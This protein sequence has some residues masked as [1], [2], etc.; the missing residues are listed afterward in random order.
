MQFLKNK[1][2]LVTL[3]FIYIPGL[4]VA[5]ATLD[6]SDSGVEK[7]LNSLAKANSQKEAIV[8]KEKIW[9]FWLIDHENNSAVEQFDV[10]LDYFERNKLEKANQLF[11]EIISSYP[12]YME[13]WNKRATI[14]FLKGDYQGSLAD[15]EEVLLRQK[16]HFGAISGAG[17]IY[18]ALGDDQRALRSYN[19]VLEIDP[20]NKE[21][22][23]FVLNLRDKLYG[24]IL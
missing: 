1:I 17:L 11:S 5:D 15:I 7:L 12:D 10:A 14:R 16:R 23:Y 6:S 4:V 21:A 9:Q 18:L 8:L 19:R 13:A 2:F 3:L 24:K 20:L 22:L